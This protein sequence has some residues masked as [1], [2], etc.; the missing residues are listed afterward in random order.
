VGWTR[1][2][3]GRRIRWGSRGVGRG[4][5]EYSILKDCIIYFVNVLLMEPVK[6]QSLV[7]SHL[8]SWARET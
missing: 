1:R 5:G 3:W 4:R 8:P 2:N 7:V 6:G